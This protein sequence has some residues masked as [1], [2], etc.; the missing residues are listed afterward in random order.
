VAFARLLDR[1]GLLSNGTINRVRIRLIQCLDRADEESRGRARVDTFQD[2]L[3]VFDPDRYQQVYDEE[4]NL[5][6]APEDNEPEWIIPKTEDDVADM[7][8]QLAA[9][10]VSP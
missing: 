9:M 1:A 4:G 2:L 7:M 10:G 8:K 3:L 5:R 6:T